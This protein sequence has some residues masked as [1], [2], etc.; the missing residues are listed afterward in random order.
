[1]LNFLCVDRSLAYITSHFIFNRTPPT[2][3]TPVLISHLISSH[4][5]P[6]NYVASH[7]LHSGRNASKA[8]RTAIPPAAFKFVPSLLIN[9]PP[10]VAYP[11][12]STIITHTIKSPPLP[13]LFSQPYLRLTP[14]T[15]ILPLSYSRR[16][17]KSLLSQPSQDNAI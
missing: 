8:V 15:F 4:F 11:P 10:C 1:M 17:A 12:V 14:H 16:F 13:P 3:R 6:H 2:L 7:I 5:F 9:S